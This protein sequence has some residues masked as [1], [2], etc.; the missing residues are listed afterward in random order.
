M[1]KIQKALNKLTLREKNT[2]KLI[3]EKIQKQNFSGLDVKKLKGRDNIFRVRKGS[4]RIIYRL[5]KKD[6][7]ILTIERRSETTYKF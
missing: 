7:F 5:D 1:D 2:A 4:L 6:I 3:L